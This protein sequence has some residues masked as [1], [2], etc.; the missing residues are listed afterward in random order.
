MP[1]NFE[2]IHFEVKRSVAH[3]SLDR[4]P[5]NLL[6][7]ALIGEITKALETAGENRRVKVL[8]LTSKLK[9]FCLGFDLNDHNEKRVFQLLDGFH[10]IIRTIHELGIPSVSVVNG[11]ALGAGCTLAT[12]CDFVMSTDSAR[13]GHPE[14]AYGLVPTVSAISFPY[15]L[16]IRKTTELLL[17]GH[18][19]D[20]REAHQLGLVTR[21]LG[22][23]EIIGELETLLS[24]ITMHSSPI[25]RLALQSIRH[26]AG[27]DLA[28]AMEKNQS[29][30]L[31]QLM[32]LRDIFEG[33]TAKLEKRQ[34]T[35]KN[36]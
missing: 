12:F 32:E 26:S 20:A 23:R 27:M 22:E 10:H 15:I 28:S 1:R 7:I 36:Q 17:T 6:N 21:V 29:R 25:L 35:W 5:E 9:D 30:Y 18:I 8:L 19:M 11:A 31:N 13:F 3:I 33:I 24:Q 34:P 4:S 14:I 2:H 16:G